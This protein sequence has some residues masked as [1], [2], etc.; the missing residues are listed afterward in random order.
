M[1]KQPQYKPM[2]VEYQVIIIYAANGKYLL[3]I[4]VEEVQRFEQKLFELVDTGYPE[5]IEAIRTDKE[6]REATE[7]QL[8][9][10]IEECRAAFAQK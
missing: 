8:V 6:I 5:I 9:K 7:R 1:L 10:V 2:P 3:D 4:P